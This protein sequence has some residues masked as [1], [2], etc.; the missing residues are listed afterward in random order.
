[1]NDGFLLFFLFLSTKIALLSKKKRSP[2]R[3]FP[4]K[5]ERSIICLLLLPLLDPPPPLYAHQGWK[6]WVRTP[7][8]PDGQI[9]WSFVPFRSYFPRGGGGAK[10]AVLPLLLSHVGER[11]KM[12][13]VSCETTKG[14][15]RLLEM[16]KH[17]SFHW[18]S[19]EKVFFSALLIN[20]I[21]E[22]MWLEYVFF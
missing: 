14:V 6:A 19:A 21:R 9:D 17:L 15:W 22:L 13:K 7:P 1:M 4:S 2:P 20:Y 3:L 5:E 10:M 8:P 11:W 18:A 12:K 16:I